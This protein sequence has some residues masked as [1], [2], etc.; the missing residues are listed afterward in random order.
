M[1]NSIQVDPAIQ[2]LIERDDCIAN[3]SDETLDD[4]DAATV[5][6]KALWDRLRQT[7]RIRV[8]K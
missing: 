2:L 1:A 5:I 4:V 6:L 7:H 8:V 3:S